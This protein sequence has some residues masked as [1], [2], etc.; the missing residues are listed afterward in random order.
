LLPLGLSFGAIVVVL[1]HLI[2]AGPAPQ[3]D[4]GTSAHVW[5]MLMGAQLP[6]VGYF[7]IKWGRRARGSAFVVL[8][9]QLAAAIAALAPVYFLKW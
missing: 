7:V 5:Q 1:V 4:E 9:L 6:I 8:G 2:T 3:A